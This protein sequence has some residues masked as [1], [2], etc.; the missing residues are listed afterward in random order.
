M[1]VRMPDGTLITNVPDGTTKAELM[2]RLSKLHGESPAAVAEPTLAQRA[3]SAV[4]AE[5]GGYGIP[6]GITQFA[7]SAAIPSLTTAAGVAGGALAAPFTGG[8]VNPVTGGMAGGGIGEA[9]N[10]QLGITE[11]SNLAIGLNTAAPL[12]GKYIQPAI[13]AAKRG[14]TNILPG[15]GLPLQERG[16]AM[17]KDIPGMFSPTASS[18]SLYT[19]LEAHNPGINAAPFRER[20]TAMQDE[21]SKRLGDS[22]EKT[23]LLNYMESKIDAIDKFPSGEVPFQSMRATQK[24]LNAK[25]GSREGGEELGIL[26]QLSKG[27]KSSFDATIEAGGAKPEAVAL[28][29]QA[30][31][32]FIKEQGQKELEAVFTKTM[33]GTE[34]EGGVQTFSDNAR[35]NIKKALNMNEEIKA[36]YSKDQISLMKQ[37][38]DSIG[39]LPSLP[40]ESP[41]AIYQGLRYSGPA[42]V[43]GAIAYPLGIHPLIGA[44]AGMS[45]DWGI[46]KVVMSEWGREKV[47]AYAT[48]TGKKA[49]PDVVMAIASALTAG[50]SGILNP[51]QSQIRPPTGIQPFVNQP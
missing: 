27:I 7:A 4:S 26:K 10:Q 20:L 18:E 33:A 3:I 25:I 30:N 35:K 32:T 45:I 1:D 31:K 22:A 11:P 6:R 28:L 41:S 16:A 24:E 36:A 38:L 13:Q 8:I 2:T 21:V 44:T 34:R 37:A 46:R 14:L 9:I 23:R 19:Q 48:S 17:A 39:S 49:T 29:Q 40:P 42:V 50:T 43:G 12:V 47:I 51:A 5:P 15:A